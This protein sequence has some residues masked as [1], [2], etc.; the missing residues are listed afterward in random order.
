VVS[1][2]TKPE[3]IPLGPAQEVPLLQCEPDQRFEYRT[4]YD[5]EDLVGSIASVQIEPGVAWYD[6]DTGKYMVIAG[7]RRL[8]AAREALRRYGRPSTYL[9]RLIPADAPLD[10][11]WRVSLEE[12][13][14]QHHL[15]DLEV[16][17]AL[18]TTRGI[19]DPASLLAGYDGERAACLR[20]VAEQA[21]D[22]EMEDFVGVETELLSK[23]QW[24]VRATC[25]H[26]DLAL[27]RERAVRVY[28]LWYAAVWELPRDKNPVGEIEANLSKGIVPI[29]VRDFM[30]RH[31]IAI[32]AREVRKKPA[33]GKPGKGGSTASAGAGTPAARGSAQPSAAEE[34]LGKARPAASAGEAALRKAPPAAP[35]AGGS[36]TGSAESDRILNGAARPG[37]SAQPA[38]GT[39][40]AQPEAPQ[41]TARTETGE[42]ASPPSEREGRV[43]ETRTAD[44]GAGTGE[45]F[46]AGEEGTEREE[47]E[48]S[49]SEPRKPPA[50]EGAPE[51]GIRTFTVR[52]AAGEDEFDVVC[53]HCNRAFHLRIVRA[54]RA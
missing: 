39:A 29:T 6:P 25:F 21:T 35:P 42:A 2:D 11:M 51:N 45:A 34:L 54:D 4:E 8:L 53:P 50:G 31:G 41:P 1:D 24:R 12:N 14:R 52:A 13:L 22:E 32:P 18:R 15:T 5:I 36:L 47:A 9:V 49:S 40:R 19:L 3:P 37:E 43:E 30:R 16:I 20:R 48:E 23:L 26:M 38:G 7:I 46:P 33:A 27:G 10:V 44:R 17:R 28:T